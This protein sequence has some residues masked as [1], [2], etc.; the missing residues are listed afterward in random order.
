MRLAKAAVGVF[1]FVVFG[2]ALSAI[3]NNSG[4]EDVSDAQVVKGTV[5]VDVC[6]VASPDTLRSVAAGEARLLLVLSEYT[7]SSSGEQALSLATPDGREQVLGIF[8]GEAFGRDATDAHKRF[9]LA[10]PANLA[11]GPPGETIE[12][13][14]IAV[15]LGGPD[16]LGRVHLEFWEPEEE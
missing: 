13:I 8:P 5:P 4:Q 7:P 11:E 15:K 14:C 2:A 10:P 6:T 16:G 3:M 12:P 1:V 9:L